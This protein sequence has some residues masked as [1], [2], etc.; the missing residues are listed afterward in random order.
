MELF[1]VFALYGIISGTIYLIF[2]FIR[3]LFNFNR[4]IQF[5][6][7]ITCGLI[8]GL[9]FS[10]AVI[11]YSNGVLRFYL[12]LGFLLGLVITGITFKNFVASASDFV[13]NR[14]RKVILKLRENV[15]RRRTNGGKKINKNS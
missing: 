12:I 10:H 3:R 7:D 11:N 14:I 8:I 2:C 9:E 13:Y 15:L 5:P 6:L 1:L 4:F